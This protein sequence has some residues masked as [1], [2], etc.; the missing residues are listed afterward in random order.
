MSLYKSMLTD[1]DLETKGIWLD[2][3]HTRIKLGRAGGKNSGYMSALEKL[4]RQYK[5]GLAE[6][7]EEQ[8]RQLFCQ[9]YAEQLVKDW[10][11]KDP[12]GELNVD[13]KPFV[14]SEAEGADN[15]RYKRGISGPTGELLTVTVGNIVATLNDLPDLAIMVK[16]T[17]EDAK[18]YLRSHIEAVSGN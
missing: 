7:S 11:T 16:E 18:L 17:V 4:T 1:K 10:L 15:R 2:L 5:R 9:L 12:E 3:D 13:G 14:M 8:N 6:L